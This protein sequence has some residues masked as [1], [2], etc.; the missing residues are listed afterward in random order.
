M[1]ELNL[2]PL[3]WTWLSTVAFDDSEAKILVLHDCR[4]FLISRGI[5]PFMGKFNIGDDCGQPFEMVSASTRRRP[6][7]QA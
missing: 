5:F 1:F 4:C 6:R 3:C 7:Q 2:D